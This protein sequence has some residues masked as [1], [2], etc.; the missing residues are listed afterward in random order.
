MRLFWSVVL[1]FKLILCKYGIKFRIIQ[2]CDKSK[3]GLI[4]KILKFGKAV[5]N[6]TG[7]DC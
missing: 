5:F 2:S 3:Q 7:L 1:T 6:L 4:Q